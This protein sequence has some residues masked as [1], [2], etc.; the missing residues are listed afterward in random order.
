[1]THAED[2]VNILSVGHNSTHV[3][4]QAD[5]HKPPD[6]LLALLNVWKFA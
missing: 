3:Y 2:M 6:S 4:V 5:P 1:M